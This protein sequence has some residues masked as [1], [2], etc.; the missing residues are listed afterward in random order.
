MR[1]WIGGLVEFTPI[2]EGPRVGARSLQ[3]VEQGGRTWEVESTILELVPGERLTARAEARAFTTTLAYD[4]EPAD[5][6][7]RLTGTVETA[8]KGLGGRLLG[9]VAARAAERKLAADLERLKALVD[10]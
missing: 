10:E 9:G 6:T 2:D 4:L 8:L 3:K 1:R 7:T 5:G